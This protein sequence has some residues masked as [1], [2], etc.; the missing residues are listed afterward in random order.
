V[1]L[2]L[3]VSRACLDVWVRGIQ[4]E[5]TRVGTHEFAERIQVKFE[6]CS[7]GRDRTGRNGDALEPKETRP[8]L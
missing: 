7:V 8:A 4:V 1:T 2:D 6:S 5:Q 3:V